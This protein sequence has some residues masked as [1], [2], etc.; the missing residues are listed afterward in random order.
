[1]KY[2]LL[3]I[4]QQPINQIMQILLVGLWCLT[5]LSTYVVVVRFIW[6]R[7][8]EYPE[9]THDLTKWCRGRRGLDHMVV[10]FTTTCAIC[11]SS[12]KW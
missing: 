7:K 8:L 12:L 2:L 11:L 5:P 10:G 4:K 9:K 3:D 1:M 6:W